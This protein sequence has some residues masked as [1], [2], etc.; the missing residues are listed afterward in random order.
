VE[1]GDIYL[2]VTSFTNFSTSLRRIDFSEFWEVLYSLCLNLLSSLHS[3]KTVS[4]AGVGAHRAKGVPGPDKCKHSRPN[5]RLVVSLTRRAAAS[6]VSNED[7]VKGLLLNIWRYGQELLGAH[8]LEYGTLHGGGFNTSKEE[9][10]RSVEVGA[11]GWFGGG[12]AP[13]CCC[14]WGSLNTFGW[15]AVI[16]NILSRLRVRRRCLR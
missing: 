15:T 6:Q 5:T 2:T 7:K 1:F 3:V 11:P 8:M 10:L 13:I 9:L 14:A 12:G 16:F 4:I